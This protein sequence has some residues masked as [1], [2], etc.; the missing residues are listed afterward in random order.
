MR[1]RARYFGVALLLVGASVAVA[2]MVSTSDRDANRS[3]TSVPNTEALGTAP[4]QP[5]SSAAPNTLPSPTP[6]KSNA[7]RNIGDRVDESGTPLAPQL[8][9]GQFTGIARFDG[10]LIAV[11]ATAS[12]GPAVWRSEDAVHW[13]LD[14]ELTPPGLDEVR[15]VWAT[16]SSLHVLGASGG[17]TAVLSWTGGT[18]DRLPTTSLPHDLEPHG[19]AASDDDLVVAGFIDTGSGAG[20]LIIASH[21]DESWHVVTSDR[22]L[23]HLGSVDDVGIIDGDVVVVGSGGQDGRAWV[24]DDEVRELPISHA[25]GSTLRVVTQY[26][27]EGLILGENQ[28]TYAAQMWT[29]VD[30]ETFVRSPL[31]SS[32]WVP[33]GATEW[34][35]GLVLVGADQQGVASAWWSPDLRTWC[36]AGGKTP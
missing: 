18:W 23:G 32:I 25:N 10:D 35:G 9:E 7:C 5:A 15:D 1:Q 29:F 31:P 17:R 28:V 19:I 8:I 30:L 36:R 20:P 3:V 26:A 24:V 21:R 11:G 12:G 13:Q 2:L 16:G 14:A 6:Q 4:A 33:A 34:Q 27:G 22:G